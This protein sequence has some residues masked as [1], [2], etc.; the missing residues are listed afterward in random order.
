MINAS[1]QKCLLD[2][3]ALQK[4]STRWSK[5]F[6][7]SMAKQFYVQN[8]ICS[9]V[10]LD[11]VSVL[12]V[13]TCNCLKK[14]VNLVFSFAVITYLALFRLDEL[15]INNFHKFIMCNDTMKMYKVRFEWFLLKESMN[16][17]KLRIVF[18]ENFISKIENV[19]FVSP[20][21]YFTKHTGKIYP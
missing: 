10:V 4:F 16:L 8:G 1:S 14:W 13:F 20:R 7:T 15:Q 18:V 21:L 2:A 19:Y 17:I 12:H 6:I 5:A 3:F 9:Q 11:T